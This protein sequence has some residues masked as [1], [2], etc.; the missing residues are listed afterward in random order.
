M[1]SN[2]LV[3]RSTFSTADCGEA[4]A[5]LRDAYVDHR[6]TYAPAGEDFALTVSR[7]QSGDVSA[8]RVTATMEY[9]G[10]SEQSDAIIMGVVVAGRFEYR[11]R[12]DE[13]VGL[14]GD[15]IA[16][17]YSEKADS[18]MHDPDIINV[19][20][21]MERVTQ[22]ALENFGPLAEPLAFTSVTPVSRAM[23]R[24]FGSIVGMVADQMLSPGDSA[25]D[26]P[27][28]ARQ[29]VDAAMSALL[30][31]FA[32]STMTDD[33]RPDPAAC[34]PAAVRRAVD[35][36]D[37]HAA[38]PFSVAEAAEAAGVQAGELRAAFVRDHD[39]SP[40][41][42]LRRVRLDGAHRDLSARTP[43]G[44]DTVATVAAIAHRWGFA[45]ARLF[46]AFYRAVYGRAPGVTLGADPT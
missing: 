40:M 34:G 17:P 8:S 13:C 31:G 26:H 6:L 37:E 20:V 25:F 41:E 28:I 11:S 32:N 10:R 30:N 43:G 9:G 2:S 4:Y 14:A 1:S 46:A 35:Y 36:I 22:A 42:Y 44:D 16:V 24:Y 39:T 45:D 12:I 3:E 33:Y 15:T 5:F 7:A 29:L 23:N 38:E 19:L 27:L 21:P 18:R